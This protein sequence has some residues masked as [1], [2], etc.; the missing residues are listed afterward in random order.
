MEKYGYTPEDKDGKVKEASEKGICP[1]CGSEL[2][3]K[4]PVCPNCGSEPFEKRPDNGED[5]SK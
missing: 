1:K 5:D 4:P 2:M 3:G